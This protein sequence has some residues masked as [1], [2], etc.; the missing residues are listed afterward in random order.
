MDRN[1][2]IQ[3]DLSAL[4]RNP[5]PSLNTDD[6]NLEVMRR[7]KTLLRDAL[8]QLKGSDAALPVGTVI[9]ERYRI[10]RVIETSKQ[11]AIYCI[12]EI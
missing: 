10:V 11:P 12:S 7:S 5:F 8:V 4:L 3:Q 1:E 2:S 6:K 9:G